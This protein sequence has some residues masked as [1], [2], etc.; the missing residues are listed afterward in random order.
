MSEEVSVRGL[1][2]G[3]FQYSSSADIGDHPFKAKL[4]EKDGEISGLVV[5]E[6]L[7]GGQVKA[8][9]HGTLDGR[10]IM[11]RKTYL[12]Q[13]TDYR[14]AVEYEGSVSAD[15]KIISG[16]WKLP[17]DGGTFRMKLAD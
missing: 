16:T 6:A 7:S 15:G 3:A 14:S 9:I 12:T 4:V 8:E 13:S 11:F 2:D 1:W 10:T 5:E 17:H